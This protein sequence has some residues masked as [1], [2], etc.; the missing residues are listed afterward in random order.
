VA[1]GCSLAIGELTTICKKR[2]RGSASQLQAPR[3]RPLTPS[4]GGSVTTSKRRRAKDAGQITDKKPERGRR[5][6]P[7][8]VVKCRCRTVSRPCRAT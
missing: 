6:G 5:R 7:V 3:D 4:A 2:L 1:F 8:S